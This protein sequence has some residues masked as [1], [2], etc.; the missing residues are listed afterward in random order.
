MISEQPGFFSRLGHWLKGNP[1]TEAGAVMRSVTD[2]LPP[3]GHH[4]DNGSASDGSSELSHVHSVDASRGTFLRPWAKRDAAIGQL[5]DGFTA[6]TDLM[7]AVRETLDK[8][9]ERQDE[10][11]QVLSNLPEVLKS[12]PQSSAAQIETLRAVA[13]EVKQQNVRSGKL[14]EILEKVAETGSDQREM[15]DGLRERIEN[16][17]EQDRNIADSL[18]G[19]GSAMQSVSRSSETSAQ[20][21]EQ[22]RDNVN[23]RDGE[24][25]RLMH[26]Q[27]AR[28]TTMLAIAIF[29]S[30]AA[31][32]AVCVMG[33]LVIMKGK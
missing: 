21:L 22:M 18:T 12:I 16:L 4:D 20:V 10:M 13:E 15:L 7:T 28:F 1:P 33:Y 9:N 24:L 17:N 14:G 27:G 19:V 26:K 31:L 32:V 2:T 23:S 8:Q 6:L 5:Q 29:L 30:I 25:Q 3:D 11:M